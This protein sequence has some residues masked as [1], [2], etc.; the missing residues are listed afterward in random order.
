MGNHG[1]AGWPSSQGRG[2]ASGP[3]VPIVAPVPNFAVRW[4]QPMLKNNQ[5]LLHKARQ[6]IQMGLIAAV[7]VT[8][9]AEDVEDTPP[10]P[11]VSTAQLQTGFSAVGTYSNSGFF[12]GALDDSKASAS[13]LGMGFKLSGESVFTDSQ[14]YSRRNDTCW[15]GPCDPYSYYYSRGDTTGTAFIWG[16]KV[17]GNLVDGDKL[18]SAYEFTIDW[19][20]TPAPTG[21][22]YGN[23]NW[24][25]SMGFANMSGQ[26]NVTAQ[27]LRGNSRGYTQTSGSLYDTGATTLTGELTAYHQAYSWEESPDWYW[28]VLLEAHLSEAG[29]R[30]TNPG[31]P[32]PASMNGDYL[33]VTVPQHSIDVGVNA[34]PTP[35]PEPET[36]ALGLAGLFVAASIARRRRAAA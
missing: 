31:D 8:A 13:T 17:T 33:K 25:L 4:T 22:D 14:L 30:W 7:P 29:P 19:T 32:A 9:M 35:V 11:P 34:V 15:Y 28:Y 21:Y 2:V 23:V 18:K 16:G 27:A 6:L 1:V 3:H 10:L 5:D 26:D 24:T 20:H 36:W 12:T